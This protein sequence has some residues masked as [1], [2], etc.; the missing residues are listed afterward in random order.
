MDINLGGITKKLEDNAPLVAF[1]ASAYSRFDG[2]IDKLL[3]QFTSG[4][5]L[6]EAQA[7]LTWPNLLLAKL[8]LKKVSGYGGHLYGGLFKG[9]IL[10][11]VLA[12]IGIIPA[13]YKKLAT[14]VMWGSGLAAVV[15][16]G[17]PGAGYSSGNSSSGGGNP[18]NGVYGK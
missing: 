2:D 17:S 13:K 4:N 1:I 11:Y 12:E 7:S 16:P 5:F 9:G 18:F 14:D 8:D 6:K 15:L 10:A 3:G